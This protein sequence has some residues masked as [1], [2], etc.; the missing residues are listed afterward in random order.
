[1]PHLPTLVSLTN[2]PTPYRTHLYNALAAAMRERDLD[3]H[4]VYMAETEPGR[5]WTFDKDASHYRYTFLPGWHILLRGYEFHINPTFLPLMWKNP[6]R[7]LLVSGSWFFPTVQA[8]PLAVGKATTT[9]FWN[10]SNLA[11]MEQRSRL[12]DTMRRRTLDYYDGFVVPGA[13]ARDYVHQFAP[14]SRN[15]PFLKLPNIVDETRFRD[16]VAELRKERPALRRK[17]GCDAP[18][19]T[20][21]LTTARI[22]PIK[23]VR[24]LVNAL[25]DFKKTRDLILLIAG[26]GALLD[27]LKARV[28]AAGLEEHIR[29][30]GYQGE[31][32]ILELLALSD[33][34]LLPS[35]GDPYPLVVIEA[36][37]AGLPVLLSDRVGCHVEALAPGQNGFLFDPYKPESITSAITDFLACSQSQREQMGAQSLATAE[38]VFSTRQVVPHFIEELLKL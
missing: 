14:S 37:F 35:L 25:L 22:E 21:L 16:R 13:W 2:I 24:E 5:Y 27:E 30:L 7:W 9:L 17:W 11:Y 15:K 20:V 23:G 31:E 8:V 1:M 10:E 32:N 28:Q 18:S 34:F 29:F 12:I 33:A 38:A 6:P 3:L 26:T 4:V 36:E 19:K